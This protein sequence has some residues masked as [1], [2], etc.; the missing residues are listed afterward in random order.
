MNPAPMSAGLVS[1]SGDSGLPML[2]IVAALAASVVLAVLWL[3][4]FLAA[5]PAHT[6][7]AAGP[8]PRPPL[9]WRW[10][11]PLIDPLAAHLG[12]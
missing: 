5:R 1:F 4:G 6:Q 9:L 10:G 7:S 3:A 12:A 11:A 2:A 8:Q